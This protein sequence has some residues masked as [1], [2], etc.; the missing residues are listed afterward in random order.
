M[1]PCENCAG[2]GVV[3][4]EIEKGNSEIVEIPNVCPICHGLSWEWDEHAGVWTC[5]MEE[6]RQ[7]L[8]ATVRNGAARVD[9]Y[10]WTRHSGWTEV[11]SFDLGDQGSDDAGKQAV[12][13]WLGGAIF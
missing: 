12:V 13:E 10:E 9:E 7:L 8:V 5:E 6:D 2:T 3:L 4:V 11:T 1:N